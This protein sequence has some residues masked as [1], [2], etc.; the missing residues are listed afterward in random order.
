[1]CIEIIRTIYLVCNRN[2]NASNACILNKKQY[3]I[4]IAIKKLKN[5][6]I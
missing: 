5:K 3:F 6:Y 1:M 4:L 2:L